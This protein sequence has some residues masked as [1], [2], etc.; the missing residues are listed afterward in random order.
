[1]SCSLPCPAPVQSMPP[2]SPPPSAQIAVAGRRPMNWSPSPASLP[3]SSAAANSSASVG[4]TSVRSS[5]AK[6]FMSLPRNRSKTPSGPALTTPVSGPKA[7][8]IMPPSAPWP[9]NGFG[10]FGSAG[11]LALLTMR[12]PI[13]KV[14]GRRDPHSSSSLLTFNSEIWLLAETSFSLDLSPSVE[15]FAFLPECLSIIWIQRVSSDPFATD[16]ERHVVRNNVADVAVFAISA[17]DLVWGRYN[18]SPD[19]SCSPLWNGLQLIRLFT[20]SSTLLVCLVQHLL[21][22]TLVHVA[23]QFSPYAPRMHRCSTHATVAVPFVERNGEESVCS[24]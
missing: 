16:V 15:F 24:L 6:L 2:G 12:S 10:S 23:T 20:C 21:K 7:K 5:F 1:M 19:R 11:R 13:W 17:T 9:S 14:C 4:A 3:S 18:C 22:E 8:T